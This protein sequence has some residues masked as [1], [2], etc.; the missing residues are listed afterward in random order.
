[1]SAQGILYSMT[2]T[3]QLAVFVLICSDAQHHTTL[4][5]DQLLASLQLYMLQHL[6]T[7][8][9]YQPLSYLVI[10]HKCTLALVS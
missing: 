4:Q 1:M 3:L 8:A 7:M 6:L 9:A 5:E 10:V 2:F